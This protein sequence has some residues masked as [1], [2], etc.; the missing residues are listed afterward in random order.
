MDD[1]LALHFGESTMPTPPYIA[2]ALAQAVADGYTF[3]SPNAG[4][5]S[6]RT[7]GGRYAASTA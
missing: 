6:L 4:L 2:A 5:L 3:Y 7:A 1:V